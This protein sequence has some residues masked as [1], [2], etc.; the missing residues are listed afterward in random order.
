MSELS[1]YIA[2]EVNGEKISLYDVL[3]PAKGRGNLA[4]VEDAIDDAII[5]QEAER[6]SVVVSDEELQLAADQFRQAHELYGV[7]TTNAWI[8]A[9][10]LTFEDWE[11]VI[12]SNLLWHKLCE[13]IT[14]GRIEQHFAENKLAFDAAEISRLVVADE[15]VARELRA[16]I[17][18]EGA[19]F[20][21]LARTYSIDSDTRLAG[22]YAG[23]QRRTDMEATVEAAVFGGQSGKIVGPFKLDDGWHLIK[24]EALHPAELDDALRQTIKKQLF[25]EWLAE[26]RRNAQIKAPLL[27]VIASVNDGSEDLATLN[28]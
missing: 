23:E 24:I 26:R 18:E 2:L 28:K 7:E 1:E 8:A 5:R 6:R 4:F 19:D 10:N 15:D 22:G 13:V 9:K 21:S 3:V 17:T 20:H 14:A 27:E 16:Q 12:E 11:S 25:V